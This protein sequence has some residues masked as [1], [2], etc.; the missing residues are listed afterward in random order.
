MKTLFPT[1]L[2]LFSLTCFAFLPQ[3]QAVAP[4]PDG[5]YPGGNTAEGQSALLG[6]TTGLYNTAVGIYSVLSL[7][8]GNFCT[9]VGAGTLLSNTADQNTATGAAALLSNTTG[10]FN[11]GN[12]AF[13]LFSNTTGEGNTATG[14]N[15]LF[16]NTTGN[17]NT[18]NGFT[19]LD[20]N[21]AG[22]FNTAVGDEALQLNTTGNRN[23]AIGVQAL[24]ISST[25]NDNTA[26]GYQALS[27]NQFGGQNTA[28]GSGALLNT[29]GAENTAIGANALFSSTGNGNTA[30]GDNAG[31]SV[32]TANNVLCILAS[33]ANV[34][35][36]CF[37]GNIFNQSSPS[38]TAVFV[39]SDGKLGTT[40]SSR[41]FKDDVKPMAKSSEAILALKPVTFRYKKEFDPT[42]IAQFGLVAEDVES[43]NADLVVRDKE[44]KPYSVRYDQVNAMLLNEFLKEHRTVQKQ[45]QEI[46]S[47]RAELREQRDPIQEVSEKM[48]MVKLAPQVVSNDQR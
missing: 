26:Y 19:A 4:P 14:D 32:T 8:D 47:L 9:G 48:G 46:D 24:F 39:N 2:I 21:T 38:G 22:S 30:L 3:S 35:N 33:G 10:G 16:S 17:S 18:A 25:A 43:V 27:G 23:T 13:A 12:G 45:Q 1:L 31:S 44:G 11:T 34:D 37:I 5:G 15:A 41:R 40:V 36:S 6:L 42:G 28:V 29:T 20:F 7:T